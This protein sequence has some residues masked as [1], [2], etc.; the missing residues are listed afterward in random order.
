[1]SGTMKG[2][3]PAFT[4]HCLAEAKWAHATLATSAKAYLLV[5]S[6]A[7]EASNVADVLDEY[8][9]LDGFRG[10]RQ[11]VNKD[12]DWCVCVGCV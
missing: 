12:P 11:I 5:P 1:M 10:I 2:T 8:A 3:D 4:E 6:C 9:K 7:L